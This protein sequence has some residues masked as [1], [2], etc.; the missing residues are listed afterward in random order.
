MGCLRMVKTSCGLKMLLNIQNLNID[1]IQNKDKR[2]ICQNLNFT[3]NNGETVG[4][5]G[6]SGSGKS[7]TALSILKL[8]PPSITITNGNILFTKDDNTTIDLVKVPVKQLNLI[9]GKEIS[10]IFQEP[11]TSLNHVFTCG[12]QVS[13]TIRQHQ[14]L[15]KKEAKDRSLELFEKVK[16]PDPKQIYSCYPFQLSGGQMQRVMIAMAISG[17]PKLLIADEPTTA[18]DVTVQKSILELLKDIQEDLGMSILF[19]THDISVI[20]EIAK[21]IL[22]FYNGQI[23]EQG[24]TKEIFTNAKHPYTRNLLES[25]LSLNVPKTKTP[26]NTEKVPAVLQVNNLSVSFLRSAGLFSTPIK[27]QILHKINLEVFKGETLGLVGE[28]GSGKTTLGR[29]IMKLIQSE[30]GDIIFNGK[31][32][33]TLYGKKLKAFRKKIQIVF[34]DPYSSLNPKITVGSIIAEPLIVHN[35][36]KSAKDRKQRVMELLKLVNLQED[37][38][39]RYPHQFSGGQRQRIGIARAL[40]L[41]PEIIILDESVSALD[42][43][44]QSQILALLKDLKQKYNLSYIF[45]SHDLN[46]VRYMSDRI[47]VLKDGAVVEE[48]NANQIFNSPKN[49]YTANLIASIP[50]RLKMQ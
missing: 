27:K 9:R 15:S 34:Q 6:E 42:V 46:V 19:I 24:E 10:M 14:N 2:S 5:L 7:I 21:H 30:S 50:G 8:L 4:I 22:V 3:I 12:S 35:I 38:Y 1:V 43:T 13:E 40:A 18:L 26:L 33:N 25:R 29:T 45:I 11:M 44:I 28:S 17:N 48:G 41:E 37:H 36:V 31:Q 20:A 47:I 49:L 16:L 32:L 23:V 39:N